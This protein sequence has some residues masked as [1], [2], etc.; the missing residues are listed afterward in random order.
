MEHSKKVKNYYEHNTRKFP[1]FHRDAAT[2]SIHQPLWKEATFTKEEAFFYSNKLIL[3]EIEA[4]RKASSLTIIDL[5]CGVG[6][7]L[8]YLQEQLERNTTYYGVTISA[9]QIAIATQRAKQLNLSTTIHFIE[10]DFTA[11]P[12]VIPNIDIAFSIEA[13]VHAS[14]ADKYFKEISQKLNI[15]GKIILIDDFLNDEIDFNT[16]DKKGKQ[17]ITDF[18]YGWLVNSLKT[19]AELSNIATKYGLR[20]IEETDLTPLMRNN[21]LIHKWI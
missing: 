3:E 4:H 18:K 14:N 7:S 12:K 6:S 15:G 10:T 1:W 20:I 16:L 21:R 2:K 9:T 8:F 5:G 13:F 11:L 19:K 17:A